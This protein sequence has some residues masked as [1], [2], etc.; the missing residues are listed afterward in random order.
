MKQTFTMTRP[1]L[2]EMG[3]NIT[4][5]A[6][7]LVLLV[8]LLFPACQRVDKAPAVAPV[9]SDS[10]ASLSLKYV[11]M[12]SS[13]PAR[14][15]RTLLD[16]YAPQDSLPGQAL[17][18]TSQ[19]I[20]RADSIH[21]MQIVSD[22]INGIN[23]ISFRAYRHIPDDEHDCIHGGEYY[24][25]MIKHNR[26]SFENQYIS[27]NEYGCIVGSWKRLINIYRD[28]VL[29][30]KAL[31]SYDYDNNSIIHLTSYVSA[32]IWT[33]K[34]KGNHDYEDALENWRDSTYLYNKFKNIYFDRHDSV[35][36]SRR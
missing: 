8:A 23:T 36:A 20:E 5:S 28:S 3:F 19:L 4:T 13:G 11:V 24:V 17:F 15:F 7:A 35:A 27:A 26:R 12:D 9:S 33:K 34:T 6:W 21:H 32:D 10:L 2:A 18:Y 25:I 31:Y 14:D 22:Q 30:G 16:E 29:V 1:P